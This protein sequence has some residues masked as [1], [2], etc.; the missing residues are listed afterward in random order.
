MPKEIMLSLTE[1]EASAIL[2]LIK[3]FTEI[4]P[5][6]LEGLKEALGG[7]LMGM[8][9]DQDE[10]KQV[11]GECMNGAVLK[12][13]VDKI[14]TAMAFPSQEQLNNEI[15]SLLNGGDNAPKA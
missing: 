14:E 10:L 12:P 8:G 3:P 1:K 9:V 5:E 2:N 7:G 15:D 4:P 13:I 11:A 6:I